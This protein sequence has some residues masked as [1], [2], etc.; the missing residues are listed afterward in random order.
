MAD[1]LAWRSGRLLFEISAGAREI[2]TRE[3]QE[4]GATVFPQ[5]KRHRTHKQPDDFKPPRRDY[6]K[7]SKRGLDWITEGRQG[8]DF[9]GDRRAE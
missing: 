1:R 7:Q 8:H 9:D 4:H 2:N 6:G 3:E 5:V